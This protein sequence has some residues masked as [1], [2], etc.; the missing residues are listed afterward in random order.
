[1]G[2]SDRSELPDRPG[3]GR[4]GQ[5]AAVAAAGLALVGL[6]Y[7]A[8]VIGPWNREQPANGPDG[9]SGGGTAVA[10]GQ[11][12]GAGGGGLE[13]LPGTPVMPTARMAATV[14]AVR[15]AAPPGGGGA[16]A[17]PDLSWL[18][19][20]LGAV[21]VAALVLATWWWWQRRPESGH[22]PEKPRPHVWPAEPPSLPGAPGAFRAGVA[23]EDVIACWQWVQRSARTVGYGPTPYQTP[24]EFLESL[25]VHD[26]ASADE[27]LWLYH[28]AR[29]D[30]HLLA[31]DSVPRARRA[32][33]RLV[34]GLRAPAE[35]GSPP[36]ADL[37]PAGPAPEAG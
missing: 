9:G 3:L 14:P 7:L 20:V 16:A 32:A 23:A 34:E 2:L 31:P 37:V 24:T 13:T 33:G 35:G 12:G 5:A 22:A 27:L 17:P 26:G 19:W 28:R 8:S 10:T 25:P 36:A 18:W 1:M 4:P 21:A 15:T 30:R 6:A 11:G 29:F